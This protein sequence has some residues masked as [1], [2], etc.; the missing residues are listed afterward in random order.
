MNNWVGY[1]VRTISGTG[2][3]QIRKVLYNSATV[4]TIADL[5]IYAYDQWCAPLQGGLAPTAG[6]VGWV[7]PAAGTL[8]S[9][10]A[11]TI[12]VDTAWTVQP[13]SSSRYL[14]S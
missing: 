9:I 13:D 4:L 7:A 1:V 2:L 12:T 8:Y 6:I 3:N 5:N 14:I 11:S 10:E